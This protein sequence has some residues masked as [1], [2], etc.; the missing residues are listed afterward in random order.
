[1]ITKK[2]KVKIE[3][4]WI[5][6]L[7]EYFSNYDNPENASLVWMDYL[8]ELVKY[9]ICEKAREVAN[10]CKDFTS[11]D[12]RLAWLVMENEAKAIARDCNALKRPTY[13]E[14]IDGTGSWGH[15]INSIKLKNLTSLNL[16][17]IIF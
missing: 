5:L 3:E 10:G 8:G 7:S 6:Q 9:D 15:A 16:L 4:Y 1:M 11:L 14:D 2:D 12:C 13:L 17:K